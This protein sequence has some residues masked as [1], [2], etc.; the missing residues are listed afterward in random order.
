MIALQVYGGN[1]PCFTGQTQPCT[2][3][4]GFNYGAVNNELSSGQSMC[5]NQAGSQSI[6]NAGNVTGEADIELAQFQ[7]ICSPS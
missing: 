6:V 2:T 7:A 5:G 3:G 4:T 1:K